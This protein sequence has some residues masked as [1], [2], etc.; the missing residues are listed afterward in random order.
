MIEKIASIEVSKKNK[1]LQNT[2][3]EINL[4]QVNPTD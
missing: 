4:S 2:D 1:R 3:A